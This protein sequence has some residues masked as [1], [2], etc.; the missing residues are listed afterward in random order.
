M[1]LINS[2]G[3]FLESPET[4]RAHFGRHNYLCI[5]KTKA[6]RGMKLCSYVNLSFLYNIRT[7]QLYRVSRSEFHEWVFEPEKFLGLSRNG[8]QAF[9]TKLSQGRD[10]TVS[11]ETKPFIH[12]KDRDDVNSVYKEAF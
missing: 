7:D 6:S 2:R 12:L 9:E 11:F 8:P 4:F 5:F 3:P 1:S 10:N